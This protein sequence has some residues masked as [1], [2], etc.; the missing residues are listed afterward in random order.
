MSTPIDFDAYKSYLASKSTNQATPPKIPSESAAQRTELSKE[1]L[2][3][4]TSSTTKTELVVDLQSNQALP[5]GSDKGAAPYP[6]TFAEIVELIT[7]GA[8]IPGIKDI[9]PTLLTSQASK[10]VAS[11]RRKPWEKDVPDDMVQGA[12]TALFAEGQGEDGGS[13]KMEGTFGDHRDEILA[14]DLP[15]E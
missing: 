5:P 3:E 9:P 12:G 15:E 1:A 14:Q 6:P 11:K 2:E 4:D 10:P 13:R 8:P 7:S